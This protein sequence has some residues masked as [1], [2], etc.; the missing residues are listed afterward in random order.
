MTFSYAADLTLAEQVVASLSAVEDH[1][2]EVVTDL[3]LAGRPPARDVGRACRRRARRRRRVV[4]GVVRRLREALTI[5]RRTVRTAS[6]NYAAAAEA[7][8]RCG[9][10]VR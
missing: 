7:N 2:D 5:M 1:L 6:A 8:S 9:A 3:R 4:A 10:R